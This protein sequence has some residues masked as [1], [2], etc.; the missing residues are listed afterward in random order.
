MRAERAESS[1]G[2]AEGKVDVSGVLSWGNFGRVLMVAAILSLQRQGKRVSALE[3]RERQREAGR[4][5]ISC[6]TPFWLL[7]VIREE[8]RDGDGEVDKVL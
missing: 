3:M 1:E 5:S 6:E 7:T 8:Q 2:K 4:T